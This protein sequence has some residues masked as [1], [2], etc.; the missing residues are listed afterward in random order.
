MQNF[1]HINEDNRLVVSK[2]LR[3]VKEVGWLKAHV[4]FNRRNHFSCPTA[5]QENSWLTKIN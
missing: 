1:H 3:I 2:S 4:Q 5:E